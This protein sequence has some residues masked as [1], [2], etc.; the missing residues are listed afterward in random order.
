MPH[1]FY[2]VI[3]DYKMPKKDGLETVREIFELVPDQ[4]IILVSAY[5]KNIIVSSTKKLKH[6]IEILQ[7]PV[8]PDIF[9]DKVEDREIFE[10]LKTFGIHISDIKEH[11]LSHKHLTKLLKELV[12]VETKYFK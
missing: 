2:T 10:Q 12:K 5:T 3:L 11:I 9:I 8:P 7:K 6:C 4:R 1:P